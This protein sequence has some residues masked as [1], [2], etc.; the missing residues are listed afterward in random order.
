MIPIKPESPCGGCTMCCKLLGIEELDK[1]AGVWCDHCTPG[2]GCGAY[3]ARPNSCRVFACQWLKTR[4]TAGVNPM[5]DELRPDRSRVVF[6]ATTDGKGL[7]LHVDPG[8]PEA[9]RKPLVQAVIRAADRGGLSVFVVCGERRKIVGGIR[10]VDPR[11][12]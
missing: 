8:S 11:A 5:P 4:T 10:R 12:R 7:V 2:V 1:R 3:E 6:D 9:W